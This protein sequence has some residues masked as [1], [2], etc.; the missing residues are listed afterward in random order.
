MRKSYIVISIRYRLTVLCRRYKYE[1]GNCFSYVNILAYKKSLFHIKKYVRIL[2]ISTQYGFT[3]TLICYWE[4]FSICERCILN[5]IVCLEG[6][7]HLMNIAD[8]ISWA[9]RCFCQCVTNNRIT[10]TLHIMI[11]LFMSIFIVLITKFTINFI[12]S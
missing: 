12:S 5:D 4:I 7:K 1:Y 9:L 3:R 11:S 10:W 2:Y 8:V 6:H